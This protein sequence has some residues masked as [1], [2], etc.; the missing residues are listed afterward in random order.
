[1]KPNQKHL[2]AISAAIYMYFDGM[3][4]EGSRK[5]NLI[6]P[7]KHA[8]VDHLPYSHNRVIGGWNNR[9]TIH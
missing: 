7:W 5:R 9:S 8:V 4:M 1:M 3:P 6:A 2:A